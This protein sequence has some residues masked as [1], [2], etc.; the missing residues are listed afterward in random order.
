MGKYFWG[1][2][3]VAPHLGMLVF[4]W[5]E[6]LELNVWS[7]VSCGRL[8]AVVQSTWSRMFVFVFLYQQAEST[9]HSRTAGWGLRGTCAACSRGKCDAVA[10]PDPLQPGHCCRGHC[11]PDAN[12]C[13]ESAIVG[14]RGH[15]VFEAD[16]LLE[17]YSFSMYFCFP[18]CC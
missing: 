6:C 5:L 2:D 15:Q 4:R 1:K 12:V 9:S 3:H 7:R 11:N 17:F 16:P 14:R 10:A 8:E 18:R 13:H